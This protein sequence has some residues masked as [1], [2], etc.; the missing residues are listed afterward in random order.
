ML[1]G[2]ID[3]TDVFTV[4]E[5]VEIPV[6]A[7]DGVTQLGWEVPDRGFVPLTG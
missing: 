1:L 5:T 3:P 6:Y 2:Y 7:A 4:T